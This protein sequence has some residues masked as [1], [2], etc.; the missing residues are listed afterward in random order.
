M[1]QIYAFTA[2]NSY[3]TAERKVS[4]LSARQQNRKRLSNVWKPALV[5]YVET[6]FSIS[7]CHFKVLSKIYYFQIFN[8]TSLTDALQRVKV[9]R[10]LRR[11]K[12]VTRTPG[13]SSSGGTGSCSGLDW[14]ISNVQIFHSVK[15]SNVV[16][17]SIVFCCHDCAMQTPES[18]MFSCQLS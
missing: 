2:N 17:V 10:L 12:E 16:T 3:W 6:K 13:P 5:R 14:N 9:D 1:F 18:L 4:Q 11:R 8:L 15:V 7:S